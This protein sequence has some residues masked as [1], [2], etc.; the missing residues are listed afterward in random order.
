MLISEGT[1]N[2][3]NRPVRYTAVQ[4]Q[5]IGWGDTNTAKRLM[6]CDN[7]T[8]PQPQVSLRFTEMGF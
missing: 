4:E 7:T 2:A 3:L 1:P 5:P 8:T 6:A